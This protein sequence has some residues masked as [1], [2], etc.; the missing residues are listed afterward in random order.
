MRKFRKISQNI[1]FQVEVDGKNLELPALEGLLILNIM[2]WGSGCDPWGRDRD[3]VFTKPSHHD[4]EL[5]RL[6]IKFFSVKKFAENR[7]K[8]TI[9]ANSK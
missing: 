6:Q 2:S 9:Q 4:R 7:I 8:L 5:S 3:S 1:Q